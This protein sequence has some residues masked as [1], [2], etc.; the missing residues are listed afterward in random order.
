MPQRRGG[1]KKGPVTIEL[2]ILCG[3]YETSSGDESMVFKNLNFQL[4][5]VCLVHISISTVVARS[6]SLG[7][8][9]R[10]GAKWL[11]RRIGH[12][13]EEIERRKEAKQEANPSRKAI[14]IHI[15]I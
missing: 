14:K 7:G 5:G 3:I 15:H 6:R 8:E 12:R 9:G 2:S 13:T 1:N 11:K 10:I 4:F